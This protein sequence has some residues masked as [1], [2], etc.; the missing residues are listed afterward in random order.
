MNTIASRF[1]LFAT[2]LVS[3]LCAADAPRTFS[4]TPAGTKATAKLPLIAVQGNRFVNPAGETVVF[5]GLALADPAA[6][7]DRGQWGRRYFEEA[8]KWKANVVRIPVHPTDWRRLGEAAYLKMLDDAVQWSGELGM[9][10]IIDWHT[11]GNK[12]GRAHV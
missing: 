4:S 8:R 2:T 3:A 5:R 1:L 9:Y 10:V 11:I 7:L 6:L 12:I